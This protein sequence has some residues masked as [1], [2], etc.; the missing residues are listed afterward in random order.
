MLPK[1]TNGQMY[2]QMEPLRH[3]KFQ[4]NSNKMDQT[5]P[6]NTETYK[7]GIMSLRSVLVVSQKQDARGVT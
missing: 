3:L 1:N 5:G 6:N 4:V 7:G 2:P